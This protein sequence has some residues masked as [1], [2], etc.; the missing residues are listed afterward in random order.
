M[1][2]L[3]CVCGEVLTTS[4]EIPNSTEWLAISDVGFDQY[5]GDVATEEL[6]SKFT[7]AFVCPRSGHIWI[8][9]DGF[10]HEPSGYAPL[11]EW[12]PEDGARDRLVG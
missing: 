8:F 9:K 10:E 12:R 11:V 5:S 4:G 2:K 6:Y 1:S 7:H 3:R